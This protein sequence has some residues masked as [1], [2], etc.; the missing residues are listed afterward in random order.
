MAKTKPEKTH[1]QLHKE[2]RDAFNSRA[3]AEKLHR[4]KD[5]A[6]ADA[7]ISELRGMLPPPQGTKPRWKRHTS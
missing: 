2:L 6:K 7:L 5:F 1:Q 3:E 4:H